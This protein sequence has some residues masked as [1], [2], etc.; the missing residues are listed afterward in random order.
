MYEEHPVFEPPENEDVKIW[1]Y[2]DFTKFVSLL[3]KNSLF[4]SRADR[5]DDPFEGSY[6]KA[7]VELRPKVYEGNIPQHI[8]NQLG[9]FIKSLKKFTAINSWHLNEHESAAM[10]KLYL[11]TN[12]GIAVQSTFARLKTSLKDKSHNIYIGKVKYI[13]YEKDWIPENNYFYPFIHKR[14]SFEHERELRALIQEIPAKDGDLNLS[15]PLF[16]YGLG[17][18]IDLDIL[19]EKIYVAPICPDWL[20]DL[21]KSVANKYELN[22]EVLRSSLEDVPIY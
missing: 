18:P 19:I 12:E 7:N 10:W 1:R 21:V 11:K 5:L 15:K 22:K 17:V 3:D 4:F 2:M 13:D 14:K 9:K 20:F 16:E 6:S 8:F